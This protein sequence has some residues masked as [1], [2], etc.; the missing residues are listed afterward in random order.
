MNR[1]D[2]TCIFLYYYVFTLKDDQGHDI[3]DQGPDWIIF[4]MGDNTADESSA[5]MYIT[6][7]GAVPS[8]VLANATCSLYAP[9]VATTTPFNVPPTLPEPTDP[10]PTDP[11]PTDPATTLPATTDPV[12]TEIGVNFARPADTRT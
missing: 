3:V 8:D 10:S 9:D 12:L 5:E 1:I 11:E 7:S 6:T 2:Y 4:R